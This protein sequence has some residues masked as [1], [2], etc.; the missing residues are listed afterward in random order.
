MSSYRQLHHMNVQGVNVSIEFS[1]QSV[2]SP[3]T[4]SSPAEPPEYTI[5]K[6][7]VGPEEV[8]KWTELEGGPVWEEIYERIGSVVEEILHGEQ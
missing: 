2:G 3:A 8:S 6:I 1:I 7:F 4:S 5:E